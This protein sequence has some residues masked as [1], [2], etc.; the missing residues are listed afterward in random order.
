MA[1]RTAKEKGVKQ[2]VDALINGA[3]KNHDED[4]WPKRVRLS[5]TP[6]KYS[7]PQH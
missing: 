1:K 6:D 5:L 4:K 7:R 2:D 3:E